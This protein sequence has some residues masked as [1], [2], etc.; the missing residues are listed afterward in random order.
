MGRQNWE[1]FLTVNISSHRFSGET[2][3]EDI[4]LTMKE[5]VEY[6]IHRSVCATLEANL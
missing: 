2:P 1:H 4:I 6:D 5:L 3:V